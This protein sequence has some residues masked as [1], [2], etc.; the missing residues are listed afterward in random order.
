MSILLWLLLAVLL[1][2]IIKYQLYLFLTPEKR[3]PV[4]MYH[5]VLPVAENELT[6]TVENLDRQ[7]ALL[8][9]NGYKTLFF[10]ELNALK[11][12]EKKI[13]IT[14]D[15][16]YLNNKKNLL[17]LLE[18]YDFKATIFIATQLIEKN[19]D[20]IFMTFDEIRNLDKNLVEIG[21]HSHTHRN[22]E[23]LTPE[24]IHADLQKNME[25]LEKNQIPFTK[26]LA[27]PYGRFPQTQEFFKIIKENKI[28]FAL[29]IGNKINAFPR[30]NPYTLNRMDIKNSTTLSAFKWKIILGKLK[31]F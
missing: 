13:I 16:G 7:F 18:K 3:L 25:V 31:L 27:Y 10:N 30:K 4:L 21:L 9:K 14:F 22:Y 24:E 15:D 5:H 1:F 28:E 6:V 19:R 26:V 17:P 11:A 20:G 29:R 23:Q 8:K 2:L 12:S